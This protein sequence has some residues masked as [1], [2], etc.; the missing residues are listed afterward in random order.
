MHVVEQSWWDTILAL[1]GSVS[2]I[3]APSLLPP[4]RGSRWFPAQSPAG[5]ARP[6]PLQQG[7]DGK[8]LLQARKSLLSPAARPQW[9]ATM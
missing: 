9:A 3:P 1:Q 4:C 5:A 8:D 7:G 6:Q 2:K